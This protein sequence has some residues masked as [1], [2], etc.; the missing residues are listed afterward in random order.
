VKR[1][2]GTLLPPLALLALVEAALRTA[3]VEVPRYTG[4]RNQA[5]YWVPVEVP[6]K[7]PGFVRAFP[8]PYAFRPEPVP[9]F[10]RDK[11]E[12][13]YRVFALGD[14]LAFGWPYEIGGFTDWLQA[15]LGTMLPGRAVE[16]VNAGNPG[17][18][19]AET[20]TLMRECLEQKADLLVWMAGDSEH[21]PENTSRLRDEIRGSWLGPLRERILQLRVICLLARVAPSFASQ[22]VFMSE[23]GSRDE[24]PCFGEEIELVKQRYRE[25]VAGIVADARAAGVAIVLCT[26]PRNLRTPPDTSFHSEAVRND[27]EARARF[28]RLYQSALDDLEAGRLEDAVARLL[29]AG[30]I[31]ASPA[32]LHFALGRAYEKLARVEPA[33]AAFLEAIERDGCPNR[34]QEWIEQAIRR[35]AAEQKVPLVDLERIFHEAGAM[36]MAG[37]EL[38]MDNVHPN[39]AGHQRIAEELLKAFDRELGVPLDWSRD[40]PLKRYQIELGLPRYEAMLA[41]RRQ[42]IEGMKDA[43]ER[44]LGTHAWRRA[45]EDAERVLREMPKDYENVGA[46]GVLEAVSGDLARGK[47]LIEQA[48]H[49]DAYVNVSFYVHAKLSSSWE[50]V[51][52]RAGIDMDAVE[53]RFTPNELR[54]VDNRLFRGSRR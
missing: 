11:P 16:V 32:K 41:A 36:G 15:R 52:L 28:E 27:P 33:R 31:D 20:R 24:L 50:R 51:F 45:R 46:L 47:A 29:E 2:L 43:V 19:S 37:P 9:L 3:G 22:R 23:R 10:V 5:H 18:H 40:A 42:A 1:L 6:G 17:W 14:S 8:R 44:T 25:N 34:P 48:M 4:L 12:N 30:R 21:V 39:L 35:T 38:L 26:L 13:G 7:P 54:V 49:N 53:A